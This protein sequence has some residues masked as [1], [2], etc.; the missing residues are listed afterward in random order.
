MKRS[1][2]AIFSMALVYAMLLISSCSKSDLPEPSPTA[3]LTKIT[4]GYATGASAKVEVYANSATIYTGYTKFYL[5]VYDSATGVRVQQAAISL[6]PMMDM[7]MM[8]HSTPFENPTSNQ[9]VNQLFPCSVVF[10]MPSTAG[11]WTVKIMLTINGRSGNLTIPVNVIEPVKS[12][13]KSFT[14]LHNSANYF[15]ALI[16]P[17]KPKIGINDFEIAVYK[18][19]SMMS[20][21]PDNSFS[22]VITP[23]M[24]TMG[25]GSP[26]NVDP[27]SVGNGHYKGKV[28]FTMTGYWKV[29]LGFNV[30]TEVASSAQFFDIEF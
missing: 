24:P 22:V 1:L 8:Q 21:V 2:H 7:G 9:A 16:E 5:A 15:I 18:K 23:E 13:L 14:S 3:N 30:G 27:V 12:K 29:N 17:T 19:E 20:F 25:H 26:N 28:N 4:E 10:I 11:S 6:M